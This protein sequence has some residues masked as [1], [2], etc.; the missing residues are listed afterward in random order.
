MNSWCG[1]CKSIHRDI[2][3]FIVSARTPHSYVWHDQFICVTYRTCISMTH[4]F[5]IMCCS[6]RQYD[7]CLSYNVLQ[8]VAVWHV[9]FI[10]FICEIWLVHLYCVTTCYCSV[11]QCVSIWHV[12]F[13]SI[14]TD[15]H[16]F[17]CVSARTP[18]V[19]RNEFIVWLTQCTLCELICVFKYSLCL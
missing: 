4:V 13:I 3:S 10:S 6:V 14:Y 17:F 18:S 12:S 16:A 5:H 19:S 7:T 15:I 8:C 11:L 2:H 1:T 9:S